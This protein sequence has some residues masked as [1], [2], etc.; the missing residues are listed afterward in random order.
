LISWILSVLVQAG[1]SRANNIGESLI[2]YDPVLSAAP[3]NPT[4]L[5]LFNT[6][7]VEE[8]GSGAVE[9]VNLGRKEQFG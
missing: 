5:S 6:N 9:E 3:S 7:L 1:S 2:T 8:E 4:K